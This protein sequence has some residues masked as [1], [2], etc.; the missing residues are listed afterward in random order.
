MYLFSRSALWNAFHRAVVNE[1]KKYSLPPVISALKLGK[2]QLLR[3]RWKVLKKLLCLSKGR[4]TLSFIFDRRQAEFSRGDWLHNIKNSK[5]LS[6]RCCVFKYLNVL[7]LRLITFLEASIFLMRS[8]S[9]NCATRRFYY[10]IHSSSAIALFPGSRFSFQEFHHFFVDFLYNHTG[11]QR[12][13]C[14]PISPCEIDIHEGVPW[15]KDSQ[16]INL[17]DWGEY[18]AFLVSC[19][20]ITVSLFQSQRCYCD[21]F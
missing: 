14:N 5:V 2:S 7:L 6:Q 10:S 11:I 15:S 9:L 18:M 1:S 16:T 4:T 8:I 3:S 17:T 21:C 12:G 19:D 13:G 20:R